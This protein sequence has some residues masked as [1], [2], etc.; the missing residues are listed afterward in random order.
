[1]KSTKIYSI[2]WLETFHQFEETC[3][4]GLMPYDPNNL[5][6][7]V[8]RVHCIQF[9]GTECVPIMWKTQMTMSP[10]WP[11]II[12]MYMMAD[13]RRPKNFPKSQ[14][15]L[16]FSIID[17]HLRMVLYAEYYSKQQYWMQNDCQYIDG[18]LSASWTMCMNLRNELRLHVHWSSYP[19]L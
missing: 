16:L 8:L 19:F 5:Y 7:Y 17:I 15:L 6:L 2:K 11:L 13:M 14:P 10:S 18:F 12:K 4:L 3:L 9:W 1:M